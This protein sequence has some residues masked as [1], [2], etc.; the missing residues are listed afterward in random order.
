MFCSLTIILF[1]ST[2][3]SSTVSTVDGAR[4]LLLSGNMNS[5]LLLFARL[6][7]DLAKLGH[8]VRLLAPS[9]ARVPDFVKQQQQQQQQ[10]MTNATSVDD[11]TI[12][13]GRFNY[14]TFEVDGDEPYDNS[15]EANQ[16]IV[17]VALTKS[18]FSRFVRTLTFFQTGA[19][20]WYADGRRLVENKTIIDDLRKGQFDFVII[21]VLSPP[22]Y[23]ISPL[24]N[25]VPYAI[26]MGVS[27]QAIAYRVPRLPSFTVNTFSYSGDPTK[28]FS[29]R[30]VNF[31]VEFAMYAAFYLEPIVVRDIREGANESFAE[32]RMTSGMQ[33]ASLYFFVDDVVI[34]DAMPNMPNTASIGDIAAGRPGLPLP[35]DLEQFVAA[36]KGGVVVAS[37]GSYCNFL[38]DSVT[39]KL[40]DAFRRLESNGRRVVWKSSKP[41]LCAGVENV[42]VVPWIP[43]NDLL[44]DRRVVLLVTHG[45]FNSIAEAVYHAKPMILFPLH[46]DQPANVDAAVKKGYGIRM[47][48]GDFTADSLLDN[49][50]T[51]LTDVSFVTSVRLASQ[52]LRDRHDTPAERV[53]RMIDHVIK[54]GDEH[55]RSAAFELNVFQFFMLD[56]FA[57]I[58][59]MA[60][61]ISV[62]SF[63]LICR[64]TYCHRK[65]DIVKG[66][67]D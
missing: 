35:D 60:I 51:I 41:G 31:F 52:I 2:T 21:D 30:L 8:D 9:N 22:Y 26:V 13:G 42:R 18:A 37:F 16:Q 53:W 3:W 15:R 49:I 11:N 50:N 45:G 1:A 32:I 47:D 59:L 12:P 55:L 4:L 20:Y 23:F 44:A 6:G 19:N 57:A 43:Q 27:S 61:S 65:S 67:R 66:K 39:E 64:Y 7:V 56:V 14:T 46:S 58:V 10:H 63:W 38:P 24:L 34:S 54:Y 5:H 25:G 62:V 28:S 17:D 40:C 29:T 36:S 33:K 48:L